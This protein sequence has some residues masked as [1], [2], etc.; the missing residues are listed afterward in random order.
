MLFS[1]TL[2][3][4]MEGYFKFLH[5][6]L[7]DDGVDFWW[8]DWQQGDKSAIPGLDPLVLLTQSKTKTRTL[9]T[10]VNSGG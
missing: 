4:F 6:K 5:H 8:M 1:F 7:N 3:Q 10:L 2:L 9:T